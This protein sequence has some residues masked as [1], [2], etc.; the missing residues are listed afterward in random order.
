[1]NEPSR[2]NQSA[3]YVVQTRPKQE[4]RALEHLHNQGYICFLPTL[5]RERVRGRHRIEVEEPLFSRYL[6]VRLDRQK[7]N[8]SP[9]ASTRGVSRLVSFGGRFASLPDAWVEALRSECEQL[10]IPLF[11]EGARVEVRSG[12][13]AGLE[14]VFQLKDGEARALVLLDFMSQPQ[15][16]VFPMEALRRVV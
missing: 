3:W 5:R 16:L 7:T 4:Y 14:G 12:P 6:F 11:E 1:M 8:W 13:F 15:K 10:Q 2:A 9:V